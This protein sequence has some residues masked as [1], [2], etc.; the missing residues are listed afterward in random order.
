VNK[1]KLKES[2]ASAP[3]LEQ[4]LRTALSS[5]EL[6][7]PVRAAT[8]DKETARL[9]PGSTPPPGKPEHLI[10]TLR[11]EYEE[12]AHHL[13]RLEVI[14]K[15]QGIART[16]RGNSDPARRRGTPQWRAAIAK[17]SRASALVA[18]DYDISASYVRKIRMEELRR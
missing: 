16:L 18:V 15:A 4:L 1:G 17:D 5:I 12:C 9:K 2:S 3:V 10:R 7:S 13:C 8:L 6:A 11:D 14:K